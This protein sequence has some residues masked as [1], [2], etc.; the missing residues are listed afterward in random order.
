MKSII[1]FDEYKRLSNEKR[2]VFKVKAIRFKDDDCKR[3]YY[4]YPCIVLYEKELKVPIFVTNYSKWVIDLQEDEKKENETL[5]KRAI[6][7]CKFLNFILWETDVK[8]INDVTTNI[9]RKFLIWVKDNDEKEICQETWDKCKN[10]VFNFLIR[11]YEDNKLTGEF[12]Y[13]STDL[14]RLRKEKMPDSNRTIYYD[15][16]IGLG[17]KRPKGKGRKK[18]RYLS[19]DMFDV[20][21]KLAELYDPP[22]EIM[23]MLGAYAGLRE[24]EIVN[25][26]Q[27]SI[28]FPEW[29]N[30]NIIIDL[31][32]E[33]SFFSNWKG[34]TEPG[35]IKKMRKQKMY[36]DFNDIFEEKYFAYVKS[37]ENQGLWTGDTD[38]PLFYNK[39]GNPLT[40]YSF[41]ERMKRFFYTYFLPYL[42]KECQITGDWDVIGPYIYAYKK[43]YPGAHMLRHCFT[44]YL[45]K[46]VGLKS[47]E[48][49]SWRGDSS[50]ESMNEYITIYSDMV[51]LYVQNTYA[52]QKW[53]F[54]RI[55]R[56]E[57]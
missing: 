28:K 17:V 2:F 51:E 3:G 50:E 45:Y 41:Q 42:E 9:I 23:M 37:L 16:K 24:G 21:A 11:I 5:R 25:L 55:V 35:K 18:N 32:N 52:F 31:L 29:S 7:V 46:G 10:D 30:E 39:W 54:E 44:M 48:V 14:R 12:S 20:M 19:Q 57:E 56:D 33:A 43:E 15:A 36:P 38:T 27:D 40:V 22:L 53:L 34:K 26:T 4:I 49:S 1:S 13:K 47:K 6:N 8:A